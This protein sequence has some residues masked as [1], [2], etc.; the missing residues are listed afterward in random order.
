MVQTID[1]I[2]GFNPSDLSAFNE[3][4][5]PSF[6]ENVYKTNPIKF[7]KA[8]DGHYRSVIRILY[9]PFDFRQSIV[10]QATY[11]MT[12]AQGSFMVRS[13]LANGDRSCPIF[14][15]WKKLWFSGDQAKKDWAKQ[16]YD[17]TESQWVLI[18]VL[19][20]ENQPELVGRIMV[21]K[22]PKVVFEKMTNKMK[23]TDPKKQ[24]VDI[25]NYITGL[26]LELDVQ[27][28]PDDPAQPL[29]KQ[30]EISYSL[31]D[32]ATD[33][34]PIIKIDGTPF[35]TDE[36]LEIIDQFVDAKTNI[37]KGKT[38]AKIAEAEEKI[39]ELTPKYKELLIKAW[40][41]L[42]QNAVDP[43]KECG[44]EEW[45][46]ETTNRVNNWIASVAMM[47]DPKVM[48]V[49]DA[50]A[51]TPMPTPGTSPQMIP[52]APMG[53]GPDSDVDDLPF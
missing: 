35:F 20:D 9:N 45:N 48:M 8:E 1:D 29:R 5:A 44:Y 24:P 22:L 50:A 37:Q 14:T 4:T 21:M 16:M 43:V 25:M 11:F 3:P 49:T 12:D 13:K 10:P 33:Y 34:A 38:K 40:D 28:G 19:S 32:F 36:E 27:P 42:K 46:E 51:P 23:P 39:A 31:C 15:S 30:R 41:Y 47:H 2:M 7:S 26:P 52:E 17:K 53:I 18:Q 6:N